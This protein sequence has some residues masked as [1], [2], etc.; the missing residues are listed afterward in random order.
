MKKNKMMRLASVLLIITLLTTSVISGTF[1]KYTTEDSA[2]DYARVAKWGVTVQTIGTLYG[3]YY[4]EHSGETTSNKIAARYTGSVD[5]AVD[6]YNSNDSLV[7]PGTQSDLGLCFTIEGTPEVMTQVAGQVVGS[8]IY[9]KAGDYGLM[10]PA[11]VTEDN[12]DSG[13]EPLYI[14]E[15]EADKVTFT[16]VVSQDWNDVK[17]KQ[18]YTLEDAVTAV[19][20]FPVTYGLTSTGTNATTYNTTLTQSTGKSTM[21]EMAAAIAAAAENGTAPSDTDVKPY[22]FNYATTAN[23]KKY[24]SLTNLT[25]ADGVKLNDETISWEWKFENDANTH[26]GDN[27]SVSD[28]SDTILA[29]MIAN[30]KNGQITGAYVVYKSGA[31]YINVEYGYEQ[32]N[33]TSLSGLWPQNWGID[34]VK[35]R[36]DGSVIACLTSN[37]YLDLGVTQVD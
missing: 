27:A 3:D 2:F 8:D 31:N 34:V 28:K 15:N 16:R 25:G 29:H 14:G 4:N 21:S 13:M 10:V 17:D 22:V 9:L 20:Y 6:H 1:A 30:N 32:L 18:F 24:N 37:F 5:S 35:D 23:A 33:I 19:D 36:A 7:A 11:T 26:L 12:Y